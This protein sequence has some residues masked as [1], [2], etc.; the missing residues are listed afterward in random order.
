MHTHTRKG[1]CVIYRDTY[2]SVEVGVIQTH[3]HRLAWCTYTH[4]HTPW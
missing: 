4:T 1:T 3:M 2:A